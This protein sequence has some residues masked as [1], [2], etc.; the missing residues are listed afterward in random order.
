[1]IGHLRRGRHKSPLLRRLS[2][3]CLLSR[4][5]CSASAKHA[6]VHRRCGTP[7]TTLQQPGSRVCSAP[8]RFASCCARDTRWG[9]NALSPQLD[10]SVSP[11]PSDKR[12]TRAI[13][14]LAVAG[15]A[16][17]AMVRSA[18]SLLPQIASDLA[19]SVGAASIIVSTYTVMH[20]S[21]QLI[22][23]P[24]GDRFVKYRVIAVAAAL[25]AVAVMLC[26]FAPTLPLLTL[27]RVASGA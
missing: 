7:V 1:M 26:G 5:R 2:T 27:A 19:V 3:P 20:G 17:Q 22:I 21:M 23:G 24:I 4:A 6:A 25:C 14:F 10:R 16:S 8:L 13:V 12:P 11:S 15:F 9:Y 18:D